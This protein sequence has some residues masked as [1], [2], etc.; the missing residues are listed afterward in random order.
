MGES[1]ALSNSGVIRAALIVLVGFLASGVLGFVRTGVLSA[2]FGTSAQHAAFLAAQRIPEI[3]F[4]L[5]AGG[6]LG[7]SFIPIYAQQREMDEGKAWRLASAVMTLTACAA[8]VLGLLVAI[9]AQPL[10]ETILLPQS[11]PEIQ[12]LTVNMT[13]I[14]AVT[15]F[16]FAISGLIMGILQSHG[17]FLLPS[18]AISMTCAE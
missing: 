13:R 1:R 17:L 16:I 3:I 8:G 14:M 18:V 15:P 5:V 6:A 9:F 2:Y 4:V 12:Q 7:S 10:V 11:T